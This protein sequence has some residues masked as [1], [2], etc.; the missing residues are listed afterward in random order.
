MKIDKNENISRRI[1]SNNLLKCKQ[2]SKKTY[3]SF[4]K[5]HNI[6]RMINSD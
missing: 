3:S 4:I 2:S 5:T 1:I 6:Q